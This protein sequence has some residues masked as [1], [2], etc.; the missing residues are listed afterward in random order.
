M[1]DPK[2]RPAYLRRITIQD[3]IPDDGVQLPVHVGHKVLFDGVECP[4]SLI[5]LADGWEA[6]GE[7]RDGS[8]V[9][10]TVDAAR[11]KF[12]KFIEPGKYEDFEINGVP[13]LVPQGVEWEPSDEDPEPGVPPT[14]RVHIFVR[15]FEFA[16]SPDPDHKAIAQVVGEAVGEA[17]MC[18][19][20]PPTGEF[21]STRASRVVDRILASFKR[22]KR[23]A[24][25]DRVTDGGYVGTLVRCEECS[26]DGL[27][28][29]PD[30]M[31]VSQ[32][33]Q[34]EAGA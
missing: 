27:L 30:E 17:S 10:F 19:S 15:E 32:E 29:K 3:S 34:G 22:Y 18:W 16:A 12:G 14:V 6:N 1:T 25:G 9:S 7:L 28:H 26:G 23:P 8:V 13:V 33:P 4:P 20:E 31:P 11:V 24:P 5:S 2:P 21:D